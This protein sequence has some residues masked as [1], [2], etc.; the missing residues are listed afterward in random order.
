MKTI[1][2]IL[3]FVL[4]STVPVLLSAQSSLILPRSVRAM[5]MG[6]TGVADASDPANMFY[7]PALAA[8]TDG[9]H[10][11]ALYTRPYETV[12]PD[13]W[14]FGMLFSAGRRW[15][16]GEIG[17]FSIGGGL[18]V[19]SVDFGESRIYDSSGHEIAADNSHERSLGLIS[20]MSVGGDLNNVG[21]GLA[22]KPWMADYGF[23]L[24]VSETYFDAGIRLQC[25]VGE[26]G[27]MQMTAAFAFSALNIGNAENTL[28][29]FDWTG[30]QRYIVTVPRYNRMGLSVR[31]EGPSSKSIAHRYGRPVPAM[32]MIFNLDLEDNLNNDIPDLYTVGAEFALHGVLFARIGQA[33]FLDRTCMTA[34]I[35]VGTVGEHFSGRVDLARLPF[36][37][38]PRAAFDSVKTENKLGISIAYRY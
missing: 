13:I 15:D 31:V 5:G 12:S 35:G 26:P 17:M 22:V 16:A 29:S 37:G 28:T 34:G 21:I 9:V 3:I 18:T 8:W 24:E 19:N 30:S 10:L 23:G 33:Q 6:E 11:S 4:A 1:L 32:A 38:E 7:N 14:N 36:W 20:G 2:V 25:G 27:Q